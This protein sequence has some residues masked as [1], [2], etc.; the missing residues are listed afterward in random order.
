MTTDKLAKIEQEMAWLNEGF[1]QRAETMLMTGRPIRITYDAD[2]FDL[3]VEVVNALLRSTAAR[4]VDEDKVSWVELRLD[5][6]TLL[7]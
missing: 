7:H 3:A 6:P 2:T 4:V 5:R 1:M